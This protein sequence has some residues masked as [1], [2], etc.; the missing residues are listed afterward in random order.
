MPIAE[1]RVYQLE[2]HTF[3]ACKASTLASYRV[4]NNFYVYEEPLSES[5]AS[6]CPKNGNA[7]TAP[8]S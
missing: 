6:Y 7:R 1:N 5:V 4:A 2:M 8:V 3:Y